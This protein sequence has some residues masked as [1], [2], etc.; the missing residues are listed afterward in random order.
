[1]RSV[2]KRLPSPALVLALVALGAPP[3]A[4]GA[5]VSN[6]SGISI[7]D[8]G[9]ANP[10]PSEIA[11]D[12]LTGTVSSVT[13]TLTGFA[14]TFPA[15]VDVLLV[16][17]TNAHAM[18]LSDVGGGSPGASGV[19]LTFSGSASGQVPAGGPLSTG[20][21]L[22]SNS[23]TG[24]FTSAAPAP[25]G[26]HGASLGA[27][28]GTNPNGAW[29]LYVY[30]DNGGD[31]GSIASWSLD[32]ATAT[33]A[34]PP[35]GG[36]GG[37]ATQPD[38]CMTRPRPAGCPAPPTGSALCDDTDFVENFYEGDRA[39]CLR[40]GG[41]LSDDDGGD[42]GSSGGT[43][44]LVSVPKSLRLG[45]LLKRGLRF[46]VTVPTS[47]STVKASLRGRAG[48]LGSFK[49]S[50]VG[51]GK[52]ALR[53]KLSKKGRKALRAALVSRKRAD[54]KLKVS[55]VPRQGRTLTTVRKLA[56]KR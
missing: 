26:P 45:R 49:K 41:S 2:R 56:V 38:P 28:N 36:G 22:P 8:Q 9:A 7:G 42:A 15:D 47:G 44:S 34:P 30:D 17:P 10:Y 1:M 48:R 25:A 18:L 11:V 55:V 14:H 5:V 52:R 50:R 19:D 51:R 6:T 16:G 21:Y 54:L 13:V 3:A 40:S 39:A 27:F 32:I 23:G 20:S 53:L 46:T 37:G 29:K 43:A 33:S 4:Q 24:D 31:S 35:S 12:G